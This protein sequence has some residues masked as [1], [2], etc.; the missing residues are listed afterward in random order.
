MPANLSPHYFKA[1]ERFKSAKTDQEKEAALHEM[2]RTIP[3]HK[4]TER[5]QSDIKKRIANLQDKIEHK[6]KKEGRRGPAME[7]G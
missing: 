7:G 5:L 2:L 3:K 4:G 6:K 1:E